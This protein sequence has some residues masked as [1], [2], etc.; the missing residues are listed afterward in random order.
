MISRSFRLLESLL[1]SLAV[2]LS[3]ASTSLFT[4]SN[5]ESHPDLDRVFCTLRIASH[6]SLIS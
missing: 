5:L 2:F 3:V 6:S 1:C 4:E